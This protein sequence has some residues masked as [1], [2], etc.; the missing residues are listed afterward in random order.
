M[1]EN[2]PFYKEPNGL[3]FITRY[4]HVKAI[5][6][7]H[8]TFGSAGTSHILLPE[9]L[10]NTSCIRD[11]ILAFEDQPSHTA[12]RKLL[13]NVF[14]KHL[15]ESPE[16]HIIKTAI[17]LIEKIE[18]N[19]PLEFLSS[20]AFPFVLNVANK[21]A[22]ITNTEIFPKWKDW[23]HLIESPPMEY[24]QTYVNQL[25]H[26]NKSISAYFLN[27]VQLRRQSLTNDIISSLINESSG[28]DN[29]SD[30]TIC[31]L[32]ELLIHGG[33]QPSMH[34]FLRAIIRLSHTPDLFTQLKYKRSDLDLFI[35]ELLRFDTQ[36]HFMGRKCIATTRLLESDISIQKIALLH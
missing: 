16:D 11:Y 14:K 31:E 2:D 13:A 34:F 19:E 35:D 15:S 7:N 6:S 24:N 3:Q 29:I 21:Q 23:I 5:L 27:L 18:K 25:I 32:L 30:E 36:V 8:K 12:H 33:I 28:N 20:V 26:Y 17:N 9:W 22:G 10:S 4:D 1:R